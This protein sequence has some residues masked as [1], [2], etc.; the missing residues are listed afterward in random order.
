MGNTQKWFTGSGDKLEFKEI[1]LLVEKHTKDNGSISVGSDSFIRKRECIF[2]TAI[3][4]YGA[5][6]QEGGRYFVRRIK[7]KREIFRTLLQR[8]TKEVQDSIEIGILLLEHNPIIDIDIHL[9]VSA[10]DKKQ[11]TSRFSDMLIGYTKGAGFDCKI[12]P[13]AFAAATV[14]DKHSK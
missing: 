8:I 12:K 3:C 4:L 11:A 10:S 9:D 14:A 5:D 7:F 1:K 6:S 13:N 2:S